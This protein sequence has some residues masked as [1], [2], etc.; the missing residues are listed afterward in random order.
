MW[1]DSNIVL[2]TEDRNFGIYISHRINDILKNTK[3]NE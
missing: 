3:L 2:Q 1:T